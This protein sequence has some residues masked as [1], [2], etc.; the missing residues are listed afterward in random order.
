MQIDDALLARIAESRMLAV[1]T[2]AGISAESGLGTFRGSGGLWETVR[3]EDYATP[4][5]FARR[6]A[7]VWNWYAD[8]WRGMR[9]AEPNAGHRAIVRLQELFPS[10]LVMTQNI[11]G[12]HQRAGSKDVLELHGGLKWARCTG[13]GERIEMDDAIAMVASPPECDCGGRFRPDVVWFGELLPEGALERAVAAA[14]ACG[15]FLTV[16][17]S[18]TVMPAAS[19]IAMARDAGAIVVEVN[20]ERSAMSGFAHINLDEKAG[21]ALPWLIE[22]LEAWQKR[23]QD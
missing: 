5:A 19:L 12:L 2:G 6:P 13:C 17:T 9:A 11:D 22:K 14:E 8:R 20:P 23:S 16:G 10:C 1:F 3:V 4:E 18:G 21:I 7:V 15:V